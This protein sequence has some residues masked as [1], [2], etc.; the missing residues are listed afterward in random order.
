MKKM[1]KAVKRNLNRRVLEK[2]YKI[3]IEKAYNF[4]QTDESLSDFFYFE[5][6]KLFRKMN[7]PEYNS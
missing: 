4:K 5:A 3:L 2:K 6:Y 1:A 7:S